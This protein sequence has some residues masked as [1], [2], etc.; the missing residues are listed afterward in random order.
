M[1]YFVRVLV[2]GDLSNLWWFVLWITCGWIL[3]GGWKVNGFSGRSDTTY[4]QMPSSGQE[5]AELGIRWFAVGM[6][7]M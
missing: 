1:S 2:C 5:L 7:G 3:G 4:A 6:S